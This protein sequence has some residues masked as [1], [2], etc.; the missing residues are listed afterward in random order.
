M[1][2][3]TRVFTCVPLFSL[4]P[5]ALIHVFSFIMDHG[6]VATIRLVKRLVAP[7]RCS[8]LIEIYVLT[9]L[10]IL[11]F[12]H[13]F[14]NHLGNVAICAPCNLWQGVHTTH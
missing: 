11:T 7:S 13:K 1:L 8:V 6:N 4:V 12:R 10:A 5:G 3:L 14:E 9:E 2:R